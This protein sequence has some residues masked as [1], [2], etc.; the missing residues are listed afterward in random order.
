MSWDL[1]EEVELILSAIVGVGVLARRTWRVGV[2]G[3]SQGWLKH[4]SCCSFV[5]IA[6]SERRTTLLGSYR[7]IIQTIGVSFRFL[8]VVRLELL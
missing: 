1:I 2:V 3:N 7:R 8:S 5:E 4:R 6:G